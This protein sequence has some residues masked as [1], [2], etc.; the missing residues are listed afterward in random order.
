MAKNFLNEGNWKNR[1][2]VDADRSFIRTPVKAV[3][4]ITAGE[5]KGEA[6]ATTPVVKPG[7]SNKQT[8]AK[9]KARTFVDLV[10]G[11]L[12]PEDAAERIGMDIGEVTRI[13]DATD[14]KRL[15]EKVISAGHMRADL[16]REF[17]RSLLTL[18]VAEAHA[19][20]DRRG[21]YDGLKLMNS[22]PEIGLTG[23]SVAVGL[24]INMSENGLAEILAGISGESL[25]TEGVTVVTSEESPTEQ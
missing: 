15:V 12:N 3:D 11:G 16:R 24:Q 25:D 18:T 20:G 6:E 9:A 21:V 8:R 22:D 19:E 14:M 23:P 13:T 1:D 4:A 10:K 17:S 2:K 7:E 5:V